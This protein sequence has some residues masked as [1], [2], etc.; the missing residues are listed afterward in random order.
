MPNMYRAQSL[1]LSPAKI[2]KKNQFSQMHT[3]LMCQTSPPTSLHQTC[4][5]S[6]MH[7]TSCLSPATQAASCHLCST[8]S[9]LQVHL[10]KLLP[11]FKAPKLTPSFYI[12]LSSFCLEFQAVWG[13]AGIYT[14]ASV[15][16][17]CLWGLS[18]AL[19]PFKELSPVE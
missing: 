9:C 15:C 6:G 17:F 2:K 3:P 12:L 8:S 10:S 11:S 16:K 18:W 1:N 19:Y 4:Y 5:A 13:S 14:F 7:T